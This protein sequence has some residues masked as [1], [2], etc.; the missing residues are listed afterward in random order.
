LSRI[1]TRESIG[2]IDEEEE[3]SDEELRNADA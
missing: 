1:R 3:Y 2:G